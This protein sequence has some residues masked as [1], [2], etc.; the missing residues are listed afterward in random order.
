MNA[1]ATP[2]A[3]TPST[4]I[5]AYSKTE[6]GLAALREKYAG[7]VFDVR[8]AP[9]LAIARAARGEL[10]GLRVTL[11]ETRVKEK[12][13]SIA[14]GRRLDAEAKRITEAIKELEDPIAAQVQ[15]EDNRKDVERQ[16]REKADA[17]RRT[18]IQKRIEWIRL[19]PTEWTGKPAAELD[20]F[21]AKFA[22]LPLTDELYS[23]YLDNAKTTHAAALATLER[24]HKATVG[25]EA[26]AAR[27]K[28]ENDAL[29]LRKADADKADAERKAKADA[30]DAARRER[31]AKEDAER[32]ARIKAEDDR[33]AAVKAAEDAKRAAADKVEADARAKAQAEQ[34]AKDKAARDARLAAEAAVAEANR[35]AEAQAAAE[36]KRQRDELEAR[37]D[38]WRALREIRDKVGD[39]R[40][41]GPIGGSADEYLKAIDDLAREVIDARAALDELAAA[42]K[43]GEAAEA[44]LRG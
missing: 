15:A 32:A 12:A 16:A 7:A 18:T 11:E 20:E 40:G 3:V 33:R 13:E 30:E 2:E 1:A 14:Y 37:A 21:L 27:L 5:V 26:E 31:I 41:M 25:A 43:P 9:G 35:K 17:E 38:P 23:E 42:A 44:S 10:R 19:A 28:T 24:M 22:A 36:R 6:A 34:D 29:A 8:T 39:R 4:P